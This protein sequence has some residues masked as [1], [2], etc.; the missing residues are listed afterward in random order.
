VVDEVPTSTRIFIC[1]QP[2]DMRRS[3]D[4]VVKCTRKLIEQD[5]TTGSLFRFTGER[6]TTL[7]ALWWDTIGFC[8]LYRRAGEMKRQGI[9]FEVTNLR[10]SASHAECSVCLQ[11]QAT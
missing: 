6:A 5:P 3:F 4:G 9:A 11:L 1:T 7:K 8:I 10:E 2:V